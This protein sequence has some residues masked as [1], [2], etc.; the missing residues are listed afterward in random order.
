MSPTSNRNKGI[1]QSISRPLHGYMR[2]TRKKIYGRFPLGTKC[3]L[4]CRN[5]YVPSGYMRKKCTDGGKWTGSDAECIDD[6]KVMVTSTQSTTTT[7]GIY[8]FY[9]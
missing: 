5:G 4:K 9:F 8:T 3:K 1:C 7:V 6:S 2:C